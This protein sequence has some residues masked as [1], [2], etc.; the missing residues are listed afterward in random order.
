MLVT[1]VFP[2]SKTFIAAFQVIYI[3]AFPA[4]FPFSRKFLLWTFTFVHYTSSISSNA[5]LSTEGKNFSFCYI[6]NSWKLQKIFIK[7]LC[8]LFLLIHKILTF[9]LLKKFQ[10]YGFMLWKQLKQYITKYPFLLSRQ[11][12]RSDIFFR[13][14]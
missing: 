8:K 7:F 2:R 3:I 6:L 10:M 13:K 14:K 9:H 4:I 5:F 1:C 12:T 11:G